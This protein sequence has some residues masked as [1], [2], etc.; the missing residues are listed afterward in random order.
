MKNISFIFILLFCSFLIGSAYSENID[1]ANIV[2]TD[3]DEPKIFTE[4]GTS[5][6]ITNS[7]TLSKSNGS[8]AVGIDNRDDGTLIIHS[9]STVTTLA[10]NGSN[11]VSATGQSGLTLTNSGTISAGNSKA[12][13]L[14]NAENSTVT[15]N[16]GGII[17]S[18]TNT[19]TFTQKGSS[20]ANIVTINNSGE[21]YAEADSSGTTS[22]NA[23]RSES[24]TDNITIIN[25]SGGHIHNNNSANT[26]YRQ[27]TV[28]VA[29]ASTGT[30]T[31]SGKIENKAGVNNYALGIAESGVT[32]TLRDKGKVIGKINVAGTGHTIK[33]QHGAGQAYFYDID[34]AGTYDLEDLDGNPVVK[35]S[36]GSI[37]Q[38]GNEMLDETLSYKSLNMRKS[39]IR[40]KKSEAYLNQD[41]WGE[42]FT[43]FNKRKENKSTLRLGSK[44]ASIG[45][46]IIEPISENKNFIMSVETGSLNIAQGHDV[47]K[48]GFLTG[49]H[50]NEVEIFNINSDLFILGGANYNKSERNILTNTTTTGELNVTDSYENYELLIGGKTNLNSLFTDLSL[51]NLSPDISLNFG[52]SYTPSHEESRYFKWEDKDIYNGSIALS[53]E[54]EIINN[55]KTNFYISWIAD[56]RSVLDEN[57]QVFY[58]NGVKGSYSQKNDL[59]K[60]LSLSAGLNY[61]YKFSKNN[62]FLMSLDGLQTSQD[63][64]GLQ[65]N[66]SYISKF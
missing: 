17:K 59:K 66:L 9:G 30:L 53:D 20:T 55:E 43:T 21:I 65:A 38:G 32:V 5:L 39:L 13:G 8:K 35:G 11:A 51:N 1:G 14:Q 19:I 24:A 42:F 49:L 63:T 6:T 3:D 12:I 46:N 34:G 31:N 37:G 64:R 28:Y 62:I 44:T 7:A 47:N 57:V 61:E 50:F 2:N 25:N 56:A 29:A 40:F 18:N 60:E 26:V 45:A 10:A 16:A 52:Y 15:N 33:L 4:D 22:N 36:A 48:T 58:V 54:Y 41:E 23:I 27:A